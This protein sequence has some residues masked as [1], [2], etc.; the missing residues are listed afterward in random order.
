MMICSAD[1][2]RM[3]RPHGDFLARHGL[4][5]EPGAELTA[6]V[7]DDCDRIL[8]CG[9]MEQNVLKQI[10]V[11]SDREGDGLCAQIVS[12]LTEAAAARGRTHLF[13][14]TKPDREE[15]FRSLGFY[16]IVAT[17]DILMME[18]RRNGIDAFLSSLPRHSGTAGAVVCN[19]NPFTLGHQTLME[20]AAAACD[21]LYIFVLSAGETMFSPDVRFRLVREG[22]AHLANA[23]VVR[24]RD[25][26]VSYATFPTYFI[27]DRGQVD[28]VQCELDLELFARIIAPRLGIVRRFVGQEPYDPVTAR[29]NERMKELLPRQGI[30]VTELPR[31]QG[32]SAKKVRQLL[33]EGRL[34]ETRALLP[35]VT[36]EYCTRFFAGRAGRP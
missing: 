11:S 3:A 35:D 16:P 7:L 24:S 2:T 9:S 26:L 21:F 30:Q 27:K 34:Q 17:R 20:Y 18:N 25:Y 10:A 12:A 31:F 14:Y 32:I 19:C 15:I 6:F 8:A 28:R 13:L 22:T 5:P 33:C 23:A 4:W 1:D 36:Y 29:Y